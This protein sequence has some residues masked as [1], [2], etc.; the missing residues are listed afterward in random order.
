MITL[1]R[2]LVLCASYPATTFIPWNFNQVNFK[3]SSTNFLSFSNSFRPM[4]GLP[5]TTN[6]FD[7][8]LQMP[9][10]RLT[11]PVNRTGFVFFFSLY[12]WPIGFQLLW[13]CNRVIFSDVWCTVLY[14]KYTASGLNRRYSTTGTEAIFNIPAWNTKSHQF[15]FECSFV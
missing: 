9:G 12:C 3:K 7:N 13:V 14:T 1:S 5:V 6:R 11:E 10:V 15:F 8:R 2:L 4:D